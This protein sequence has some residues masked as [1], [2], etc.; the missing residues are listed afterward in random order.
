[1]RLSFITRPKSVF[2]A[3]ARIISVFYSAS[4]VIMKYWTL[5]V[6]RITVIFDTCT[7]IRNKWEFWWMKFCKFGCIFFLWTCNKYNKKIK[8]FKS[9]DNF[10]LFHQKPVSQMLI[11][12]FCDN[13]VSFPDSLNPCGI[14]MKYSTIMD[15]FYLIDFATAAQR[16]DVDV[17]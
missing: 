8:N 2:P 11:K 13:F 17:V 4:R 9:V 7:K 15:I 12:T 10:E 5:I 3:L 1:M 6:Y 14:K 16:Y